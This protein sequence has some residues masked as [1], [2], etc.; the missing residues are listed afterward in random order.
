[1]DC[2]RCE[3]AIRIQ[4]GSHVELMC[5]F[6][7]AEVCVREQERDLVCPRAL[8][9]GSAEGRQ[10]ARTVLLVALQR[11]QGDR[12]LSRYRNPEREELF[13]LVE[14]AYLDAALHGP[15]ASEERCRRA[16]LESLG[17]EDIGKAGT[18]AGGEQGD[19]VTVGCGEGTS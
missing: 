17:P 11:G 13:A 16:W 18:R 6:S 4:R 14:A 9:L 1:L 15:A 5:V 8:S 12:L 10:I 7:G 3:D 19:L 2:R